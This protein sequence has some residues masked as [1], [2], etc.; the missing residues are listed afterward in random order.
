MTITDRI[1]NVIDLLTD[2]PQPTCGCDDC[3]E[4]R[5]QILI[6]AVAQLARVVSELGV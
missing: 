5:R 2:G 3:A 6:K 4:I 1:R